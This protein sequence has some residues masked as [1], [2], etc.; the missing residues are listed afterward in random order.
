MTDLRGLSDEAFLTTQKPQA[1]LGK[2]NDVRRKKTRKEAFLS[3]NTSSNTIVPLFI[4]KINRK[5]QRKYGQNGYLMI[6]Y[7]RIDGERVKS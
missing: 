2:N 4:I 1:T 6:K 5:S 3:V 7:S